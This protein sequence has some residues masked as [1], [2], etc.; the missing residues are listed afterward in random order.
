MVKRS[1]KIYIKRTKKYIFNSKGNFNNIIVY[2]KVNSKY[3]Y[4]YIYIIWYMVYDM[5]LW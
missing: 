3:I 2:S 4:I 5:L 1:R